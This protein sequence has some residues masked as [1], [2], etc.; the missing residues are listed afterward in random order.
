L[1]Y[2]SSTDL[3]W[4]S[5]FGDGIV[6]FDCKTYTFVPEN[7]LKELYPEWNNSMFTSKILFDTVD[8][9]YGLLMNCLGR[10]KNKTVH[11]FYQVIQHQNVPMVCLQRYLQTKSGMI[12]IAGY[13]VVK[14]FG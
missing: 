13:S 8:S 6:V 9:S 14:Y 5:T 7:K 12:Y 3:L 1:L 2:D 4:C 11:S 10:Y